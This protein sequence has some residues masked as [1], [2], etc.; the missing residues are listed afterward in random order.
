MKAHLLCS[1]KQQNQSTARPIQTEPKIPPES[2]IIS[3]RDFWK[4]PTFSNKSTDLHSSLP[5]AGLAECKMALLNS[6]G[7]L[8]EI[9]KICIESNKREKSFFP[10]IAQ[11]K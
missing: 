9:P 3:M 7:P 4:Y 2:I 10:F 8:I 11:K 5:Y 1:S 6:E